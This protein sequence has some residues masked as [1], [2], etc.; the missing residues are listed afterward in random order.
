MHSMAGNHL[1]CC[2]VVPLHLV[3]SLPRGQEGLPS[4]VPAAKRD[5]PQFLHGSS[6]VSLVCPWETCLVS[7]G[8]LFWM[9]GGGGEEDELVVHVESCGPDS[10]LLV[11]VTGYCSVSSSKVFSF[12]P[13]SL[14]EQR[15]SWRRNSF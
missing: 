10:A 13:T 5:W 2:T 4:W 12:Q 14:P 6:A 1:P 9:R 3:T 8:G 11:E 15:D 7:T